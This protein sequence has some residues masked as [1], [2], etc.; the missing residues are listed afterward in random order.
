MKNNIIVSLFLLFSTLSLSSCNDEHEYL[1]SGQLIAKEL[2]QIIDDNNISRIGV[3]NFEQFGGPYK[4]ATSDYEFKNELIRLYDEWYNLN[5]MVYSEVQTY[6]D[7]DN[8][9]QMLML[10]FSY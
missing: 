2:K 1:T 10:Y 5:F 8:Q 7:N 6:Y 9:G 4:K 3:D